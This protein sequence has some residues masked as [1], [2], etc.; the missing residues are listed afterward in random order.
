MKLSTTA[1]ASV[2][3]S[4]AASASLYGESSLNH[5][6]ALQTPFLSCSAEAY[7]NITDSCCTETFGGLVL[8]T[9][10]WDTYTGLESSGQILPKDT[11]TL[12]GLW[13][14][15]CDGS[16]TQ[17]CDLTRQYDPAPSPNTTNYPKT[18]TVVPSYNGSTVDTFLAPFGKYDLLAYMN[19]YWVSQGSSN[20]FFWAH[21]F[22]KH[23]TCFS[24]FDLP[25]YGPEY[26][27]HEDVVDFFTTALSYYQGLPTYNWLSFASITPSNTTSYSLSAIQSAL[28]NKFGALPYIGCSG[29]RFNATAAGNGTLDNGYTVLSEVWYYHH[30]LGRVQNGRAV[31]VD[32]SINGGSVTSCA[33]TPGALKYLKRTVGSEA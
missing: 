18:G 6:C 20:P 27:K 28:T 24:S 15:Y 22:S 13:P 31:P 10:Y 14:D 3:L 16:Y 5:T 7:P 19:K 12:H 9:Q 30:V 29:P 26:R 33:K 4:G 25:C 23:A 11:W 8:S 1:T 21:E 2:A 32:A 17:Y